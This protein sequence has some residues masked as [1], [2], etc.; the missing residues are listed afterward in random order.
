MFWIGLA[1]GF[2]LCIALVVTLVAIAA[3]KEKKLDKD[4]YPEK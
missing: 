2:C 4:S 3:S 1:V